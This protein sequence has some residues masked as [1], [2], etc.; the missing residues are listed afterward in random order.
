MSQKNFLPLFVLVI[1]GSGIFC[2]GHYKAI[3]TGITWDDETFGVIETE[4][5][6]RKDSLRT[7]YPGPRLG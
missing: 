5:S 2:H 4:E 7:Q 6:L 3:V 1:L